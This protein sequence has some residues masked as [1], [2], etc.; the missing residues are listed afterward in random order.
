MNPQASHVGGAGEVRNA[1]RPAL[2][3]LLERIGWG[4]FL[5]LI[6]GLLLVPQ[7]QVPEGTWLL[8]AGVILLGVNVARYLS[9]IAPS[10]FTT[11]L[12]ILAL[13]GGVGVFYGVELP[14]LPALLILVGVGMI[15]RPL[16]EHG[17]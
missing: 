7:G 11:V 16:F 4:L 6:G 13:A 15:F 5:I 8:G 9:G 14:L 12:G 17:R 2:D 1:E 10:Y 3:Q